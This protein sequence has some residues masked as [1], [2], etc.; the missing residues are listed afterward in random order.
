MI[1]NDPL[2][3]EEV[4]RIHSDLLLVRDYPANK[5]AVLH[6]AAAYRKLRTKPFCS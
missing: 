1:A 6:R 3:S 4:H 5:E 2:W